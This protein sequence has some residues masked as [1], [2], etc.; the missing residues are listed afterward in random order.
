MHDLISL[1]SS[2]QIYMATEKDY[3]QLLATPVGGFANQEAAVKVRS[4]RF[5]RIV[6]LFTHELAAVA[7]GGGICHVCAV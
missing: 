4:A 3:Q 5:N 6:L 7:Y 2:F 1:C